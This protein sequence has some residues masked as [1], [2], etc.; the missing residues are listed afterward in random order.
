MPIIMSDLSKIALGTVQFGLDYGVSNEL[1][2]PDKSAV[3]EILDFALENNI[4]TLD[5][6]S[7]YGDSESVLGDYGIDNFQIVT[8]FLPLDIEKGIENSFQESL[9]KLQTKAIYGYLAH[10]AD[11]I[12]INTWSF[13]NE[14]KESGQVKKIGYSLQSIDEFDRAYEKGFLPDLIQVPF[15]L[16]DNRFKELCKD[17][18]EKGVEIHTRSTFLQGLFFL[19]EEELSNFQEVKQLILELQEQHHNNLAQFLLSYVMNQ[20]FIDKVVI[21]VQSKKQLSQNI[22]A[23]DLDVEIN[24]LGTVFSDKILNPA[25]WGKS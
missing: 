19:K 21:G 12:D 18:S 17:L 23:L 20:D 11:S 15:N 4:T 8:K 6:A 10:R 14:L 25:L 5:T 13:L 22:S 16:L 2:K 7:A 9:T 1:G 3:R 24:D